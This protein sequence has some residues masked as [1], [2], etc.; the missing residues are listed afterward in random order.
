MVHF[1]KEEAKCTINLKEEP[2]W[3]N[4]FPDNAEKEISGADFFAQFPFYYKNKGIFV[5]CR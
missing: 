2:L 3:L 5:S 4:F 1:A